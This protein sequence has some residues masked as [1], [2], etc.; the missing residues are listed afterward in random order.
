MATIT[1]P[2]ADVT[3]EEVSLALRSG[4]GSWYHVLPGTEATYAFGAPHPGEPDAILVGIGSGRLWRTQVRIAR[5][6]G[7]SHI[8]VASAPGMPLTWL[9]N[10]LGITRKV[11][12]VL[13]GAPGLGGPAASHET[14]TSINQ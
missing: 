11:Y 4:L 2:R 8:Q 14:D 5:G 3:P 13:R 1:I 10:T 6:G 7:Q 12:R 9:I